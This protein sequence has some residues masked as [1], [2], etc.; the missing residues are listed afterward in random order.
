VHLVA[1]PEQAPHEVGADEA[2]GAGDHHA[3]RGGDP[4]DRRS[5]APGSAVSRSR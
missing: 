1:V 4:V 2:A 5:A 3:A